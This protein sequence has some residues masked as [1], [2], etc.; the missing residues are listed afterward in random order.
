MEK[1]KREKDRE[2]DGRREDRNAIAVRLRA[3]TSVRRTGAEL[4]RNDRY[5]RARR[6]DTKP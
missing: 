2:R 6:S 3:A 4:E 1:G 5:I